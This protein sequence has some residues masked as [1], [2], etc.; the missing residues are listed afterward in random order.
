M[1]FDSEKTINTILLDKV[2]PYLDALLRVL[3]SGG[4]GYVAWLDAS[5]LPLLI[6]FGFLVVYTR[7]ALSSWLAA[8]AYYLVSSADLPIAFGIYFPEQNPL[9]GYLFWI[10]SGALLGLPWLLIRRLADIPLFARLHDL[11]FALLTFLGL[12]VS[13]APPFGLIHW[14]H[15]GLAAGMMFPGWGIWALLLSFLIIAFFPLAALH[16]K[17]GWLFISVVVGIALLFSYNNGAYNSKNLLIPNVYAVKT[18]KGEFSPLDGYERIQDVRLASQ[19]AISLNVPLVVFPEVFVGVMRPSIEVL[20][21]P[22]ET[23]MRDAGVTTLVGADVPI[24]EGVYDNALVGFGA[25]KGSVYRARLPM[26]L[27]AFPWLDSRQRMHF[28]DNPVVDVAGQ[29][30]FFSICYESYLLEHAVVAMLFGAKPDMMLTSSNLWA[31]KDLRLA[32][33]QGLSIQMM[34]RIMGIPVKW[35]YN[36]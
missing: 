35:S 17:S 23:G 1:Y 28:T 24:S 30:I 14:V 15:P 36:R 6:V 4:L 31:I 20:L 11:R 18:D 12:I 25:T 19:E 2:N 5:Y 3:V 32:R 9:Y 16:L 27:N 8:V 26:P 13:L 21:S 7:S 29:N 34:A 33:I 22:I 10:L